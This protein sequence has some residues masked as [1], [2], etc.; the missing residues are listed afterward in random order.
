MQVEAWVQWVRNKVDSFEDGNIV[1]CQDFMN[2][3][4]MKYNQIMGPDDDCSSSIT[5]VQ[6]NIV[7][8][9]DNGSNDNKRKNDDRENTSNKRNRQP[10]LFINHYKSPSNQSYKLGDTKEWNGTIFHY[11]DAPT[12]KN[13]TKWHTQTAETCCTRLCWLENKNSTNTYKNKFTANIGDKNVD[14]SVQDENEENSTNNLLPS[15]EKKATFENPPIN[16][17]T[18]LLAFALNA[19]YDNHIVR[20]LIADAINASS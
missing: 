18:V 17:I 7:A 8:M 12:H 2:S 19:T 1:N 16:N 15:D 3:A 5:T 11:C 6:D 20:D 10:P 9:I 14:I 13:R 4:V